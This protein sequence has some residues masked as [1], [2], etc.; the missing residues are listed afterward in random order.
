MKRGRAFGDHFLGKRST[1]RKRQ[2]RKSHEVSSANMKN[3]RRS[4]GLK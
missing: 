2:L 1:K 4:L 3:V